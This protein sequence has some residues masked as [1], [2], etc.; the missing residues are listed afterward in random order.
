M[1][2]SKTTA[3]IVLRTKLGRPDTREVLVLEVIKIL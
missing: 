2:I 3:V 1:S